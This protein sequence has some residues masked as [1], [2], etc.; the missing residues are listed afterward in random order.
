MNIAFHCNQLALRAEVAVYDYAK[1]NE[2]LLNNKSIVIAKDPS[3]WNY[4]HPKAV[5]KFKKRF[6][7]F[8]YHDIAEMESILDSNDI[9]IFYALKAGRK[10]EVI[11]NKRKTVIH[12]VFQEYE[13]HGNVYAYISR[14]LGNLY[15][16]PY[17]PF[18]VDLPDVKENMRD[19]LRIPKDA[20]VFGRYG[21]L[22]TFDIEWV[23]KTIK[24]IVK[25]RDDIFFIFMNTHNFGDHK[26]IIYMEGEADLEKKV[27]FI[28]TC[29]AMLHARYRGESFGLAIA[30]FSL[31][32]KPIITWKGQKESDLAHI[33]LLG[34]TAYYYNDESELYNILINFK[35]EEDKNWNRYSQFNP[36]NV[37]EQFKK[38]FID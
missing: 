34:E 17:V 36:K 24:E 38:I 13:P 9:N 31:R 20:I 35:K 32:N 11:S 2:E 27:K 1:Y 16:S 37:M 26:N 28:N 10:D 7:V 15:N 14:W 33:D 22:E 29:D 5:E 25:K 21:G 4:S 23:K 18:M 19:E 3:I 12:A 8:F 30:E 6:K